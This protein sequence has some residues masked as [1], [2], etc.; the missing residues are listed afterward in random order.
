MFDV[1]TMQKVILNETIR[2]YTD[3]KAYC[4][5][6][7]TKQSMSKHCTLSLWYMK[8]KTLNVKL[9]FIIFFVKI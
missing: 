2:N 3:L 7:F 4:Y 5:K 8:T 9:Y 6:H 1:S